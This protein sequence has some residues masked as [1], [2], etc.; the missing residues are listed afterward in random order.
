MV[1]LLK[2]VD[3]SVAMLNNQMVIG[4]SP[5]FIMYS[6]ESRMNQLQAGEEAEHLAEAGTCLNPTQTRNP[7]EIWVYIR[8]FKRTLTLPKP[9]ET[10]FEWLDMG[11]C[12]DCVDF[13]VSGKLS[14]VE[15]KFKTQQKKHQNRKVEQDNY[16]S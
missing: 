15:A 10:G 4:D 2:M 7:Q 9:F 8:G 1:Y 11:I 16:I 6:Y 12:N 5:L 14:N 3:L 13:V